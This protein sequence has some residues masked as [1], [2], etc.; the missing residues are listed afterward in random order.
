MATITLAEA[1]KLVRD[2]LKAGVI[3]NIIDV[4]PFNAVVPYTGYEGQGMI[5]N[6]EAT[7]GDT[8][9]LAIDG[10]ITAKAAGTRTQ[11]TYQ[12]TTIIGDAEVNGL[13]DVSSTGVDLMALEVAGKAKDLGRKFQN[14]MVNGTGAGADMNS[15]HT[16]CDASQYTTASVGQALSFDLLDELLMLVTLDTPDFIV[17]PKRTFASFRKLYRAASMV[18]PDYLR[19]QFGKQAGLSVMEYLGIPVFR[20]DWMSITETAN[21]AALTGGALASVF[22]GC[23]DD[24]TAKKGIAAIH[25]IA[26]PAGVAIEHIG[27]AEL[28]DNQIVR[29][30]QYVNLANFGIKGLARLPS[31]N[32]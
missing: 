5:D 1:K 14:G 19:D 13:L 9:F 16:L 25:P 2:D 28:K 12:A 20:N 10:T 15:M 7:L 11:Q 18:M 24:G 23:F 6:Y 21:G 26:A 31:I 8:Q 30:K 4:N 32:N 22:A 29:V 27:A 17:M 3:Q